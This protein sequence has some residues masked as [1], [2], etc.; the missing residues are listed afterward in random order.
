MGNLKQ[1]LKISKFFFWSLQVRTC[2]YATRLI[3]MIVMRKT[4]IIL[5]V[6]K[7]IIIKSSN[8]NDIPYPLDSYCKRRAPHLCLVR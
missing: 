2:V 7:V 1:L 4:I 6:L 3:V 5:A 8:D